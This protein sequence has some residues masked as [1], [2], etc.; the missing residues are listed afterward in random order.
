MPPRRNSRCETRVV[1]FVVRIRHRASDRMM[2][3]VLAG[4]PSRFCKKG[5]WFLS[6]GARCDA[7]IGMDASMHL[8]NFFYVVFQLAVVPFNC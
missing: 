4:T 2:V 5:F 1:P 6:S 7:D 3:A 8:P